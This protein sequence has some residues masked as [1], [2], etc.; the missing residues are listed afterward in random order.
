MQQI[1][2]DLYDAHELPPELK[3]APERQQRLLALMA[4]AIVAVWQSEQEA[5]D[6]EC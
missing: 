5:N 2:L 6:D 4:E 1:T 3:M